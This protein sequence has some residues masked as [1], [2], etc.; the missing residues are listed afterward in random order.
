MR[1]FECYS[2]RRKSRFLKQKQKLEFF[3]EM[4]T[5]ISADEERT[6]LCEHCSAEN[7]I[8]QSEGAWAV[9]DADGRL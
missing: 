3:A 8:T 2:C 1:Q 6:Y 5:A 9:I 4:K 7:N